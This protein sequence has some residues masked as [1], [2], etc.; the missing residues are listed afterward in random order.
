MEMTRLI[1]VSR[2]FDA[3]TAAISES[4]TSLRDAVKTLGSNG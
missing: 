2:A 3:I 1:G 4:E